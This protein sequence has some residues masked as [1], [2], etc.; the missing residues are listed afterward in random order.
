MKLDPPS[1]QR[2]ALA[3]LRTRFLD[4]AFNSAQVARAGCRQCNRLEANVRFRYLSSL[5]AVFLASLS[6]Y[7]ATPKVTSVSPASGP[8]STQVQINGSGFGATQGSNT[9][10]FSYPTPANPGAFTYPNAAVV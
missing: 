1:K 9:V 10:A 7:A 8:V 5:I 6:L 3:G 4:I 2:H